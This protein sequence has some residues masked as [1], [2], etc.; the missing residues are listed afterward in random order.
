MTLRRGTVAG[1]MLAAAGAAGYVAERAVARRWRAPAGAIAAA[2]RTMPADIRHHFVETSDGGR[3]H[4]TERGEGQP[5]VFLHGITLGV[6]TWAPEFRAFGGRSVA[7]AFRGHGQSR[8]GRDG[9]SFGRLGADVL[10]VLEAIG[11]EDAVLVGHSMGGMVAQLLA[12][13]RP[14]ELSRVVRRLVLVATSPGSV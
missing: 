12:A 5:V 11:V 6:A 8:A 4:V 3:I 1:T 10:E 7:I 14:A 9:Y 2:G 13:D